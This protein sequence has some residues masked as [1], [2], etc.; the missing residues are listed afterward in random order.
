LLSR[1]QV[2]EKALRNL[3]GV[4]RTSFTNLNGRSYQNLV[5]FAPASEWE[6]LS[7]VTN[8]QEERGNKIDDL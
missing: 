4:V 7:S 1:D 6:A 3:R 2:D 8:N 5:S